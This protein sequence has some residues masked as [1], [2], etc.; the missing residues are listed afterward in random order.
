MAVAGVLAGAKPVVLSGLAISEVSSPSIPAIVEARS[1]G[2]VTPVVGADTVVPFLSKVDSWVPRAF[3]VTAVEPE[4]SMY[5]WFFG[6]DVMVNPLV[7]SQ[8]TTDATSAAVGA[9]R[10]RHWSGVR[11]WRY[12]A[13]PG[14]DTAVANA[15]APARSDRLRTAV[16]CCAV[17]AETA[18]TR[19]AR[20]THDGAVWST[21]LPGGEELAW[22]VGAVRARA[23]QAVDP[24]TTPAVVFLRMFRPF[25]GSRNREPARDRARDAARLGS[26]PPNRL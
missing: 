3:S 22:A 5:R 16:R 26:L 9:N 13:V 17:P 24:T 10:A 8:D 14:V 12:C 7:R 4:N 11:K 18:A 15:S 19:C 25:M 1:A 21:R 20:V 23:T 6:M 2:T